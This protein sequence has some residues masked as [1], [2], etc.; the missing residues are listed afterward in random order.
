MGL[1]LQTREV[2]LKLAHASYPVFPVL[3]FHR[4]RQARAGDSRVRRAGP[5]IIV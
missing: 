5:G 4:W 2:A 3:L 1:P